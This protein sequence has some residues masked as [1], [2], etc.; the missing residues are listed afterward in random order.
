MINAAKELARL[1]RARTAGPRKPRAARAEVVDHAAADELRLYAENTGELYQQKLAI[2][3][4][5]A[6]KMHAGKYDAAKAPK[7]WAYWIEAAAKRYVWEVAGEPK[8]RWS[9]MFDAPTRRH[10]ARELAGE[11]EGRIRQQLAHGGSAD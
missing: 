10:V 5:L 4:A 1:R 6:K 11:Y 3:R 9:K 8:D 7:L 2:I